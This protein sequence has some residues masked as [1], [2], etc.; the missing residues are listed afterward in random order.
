[1][2]RYELNFQY[3]L[4]GNQRQKWNNILYRLA[5]EIFSCEIVFLRKIV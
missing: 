3:N 5:I 4:H 2:Y 1:M